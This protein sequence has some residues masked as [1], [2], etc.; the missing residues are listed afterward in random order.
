M[1][2]GIGLDMTARLTYAEHREAIREAVAL[3]YT[4]AWTPAGFAPDA[5]HTC[6]QWSQ[7][8]E[9]AGGTSFQTGISV[10]PVP[11]WQVSS[12]ASVAAT[13]GQLTGSRFSL[14]IGTGSITSEPYRASL[15]LPAYPADCPDA[16]LPRHSARAASW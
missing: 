14:G 9:T 8:A 6:V 4:S 16:R 5:F 10:V 13:T 15:G 7:A 3:G 12:L 1:E 2:I 11:I